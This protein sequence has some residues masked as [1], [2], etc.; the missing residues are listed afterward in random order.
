VFDVIVGG[1]RIIHGSGNPRYAADIGVRRERIAVIGTLSSKSPATAIDAQD[2]VVCPG[3]IDMHSHSDLMP[4]AEPRHDPKIRQAVTTELLG[5][6]YTHAAGN[7]S[8]HDFITRTA[9][10][11][12]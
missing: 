1:G 10:W 9:P 8:S 12:V 5:A 7:H 6:G 4:L 11:F 2:H 3:F